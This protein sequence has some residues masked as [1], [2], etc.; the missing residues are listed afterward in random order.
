[1]ARDVTGFVGK[2]KRRVLFGYYPQI[3]MRRYAT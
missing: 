3:G 1:L 2:V